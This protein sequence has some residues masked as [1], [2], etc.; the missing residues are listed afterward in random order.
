MLAFLL[1]NLGTIIVGLILLAIV[2]AII[3]KI[4]RDRQKG[5]CA[6]CAHGCASCPSDVAASCGEKDIKKS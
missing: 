4:V 2:V 6:G 3:V 1:E 5:K